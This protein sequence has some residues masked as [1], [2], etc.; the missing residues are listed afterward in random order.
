MTYPVV[1]V[2][3]EVGGYSVHVPALRGCHTQ[4]ETVPEALDMARE[5]IQCYLESLRMRGKPIPPSA[6]W[7]TH[8]SAPPSA[9]PPSA[10]RRHSS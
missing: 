10:S 6:P 7:P 9:V 2:R 3:E 1:L 8:H 5:A 4:G